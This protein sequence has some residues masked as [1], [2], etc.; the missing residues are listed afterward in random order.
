MR[1]MDESMASPGSNLAIGIMAVRGADV[2]NVIIALTVVSTP[3][4]ARIVRSVVIGLAHTQF[5]EA[6]E[7]TGR[8]VWR[9]SGFH[10]LPNCHSQ[11]L[12]KASFV[13]AKAVLGE[14]TLSFFGAGEP[15]GNPSWGGRLVESRLFLSQAPWAMIV[16]RAH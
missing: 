10:S 9:V 2:T 12:V 7:S 5:G 11:I 6:A 16:P 8:T 15:P 1:V 13:F 3:R 4:M 14:S